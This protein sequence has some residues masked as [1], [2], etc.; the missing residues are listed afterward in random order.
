MK[1]L[2]TK[3]R[4]IIAKNLIEHLKEMRFY[5]YIFLVK[6]LLNIL[7]TYVKEVMDFIFHLA[8]VNRPKDINEFL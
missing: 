4:W 6:R 3:F 7:E 1:I 8:G 5:N 2:I